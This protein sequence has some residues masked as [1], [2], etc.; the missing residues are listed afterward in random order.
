MPNTTK[1]ISNSEKRQSPVRGA[2]RKPSGPLT[3]LTRKWNEIDKLMAVKTAEN[4]GI[5]SSK[6]VELKVLIGT[7]LHHCEV[8]L[9]DL[10]LDGDKTDSV[11]SSSVIILS[12]V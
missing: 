6:I 11:F 5:V 4:A 3:A 10:E 1:S 12:F 2:R 7:F 8:Y 9:E